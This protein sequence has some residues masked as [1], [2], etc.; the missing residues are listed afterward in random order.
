VHHVLK[1]CLPFVFVAMI[2]QSGEVG[3]PPPA[4]KTP[5]AETLHGVTIKDDYRWPEDQDSA[6]TRAWIAA[7]QRYAVEFFATLPQRAK[8]RSELEVLERV[9]KRSVPHVA[10]GRYFFYETAAGR[11]ASLRLYAEPARRRTTTACQCEQAVG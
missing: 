2:T 10:N 1:H 11:A 7:Q 8:I 6:Q 3:L 5:V 4:Q 9:E